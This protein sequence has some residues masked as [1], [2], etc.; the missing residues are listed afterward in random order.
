MGGLRRTLNELS[1]AHFETKE[2]RQDPSH[3]RATY[4][5]FPSS[6]SEWGLGKSIDLINW[7]YDLKTRRAREENICFFGSENEFDSNGLRCG[8]LPAFHSPPLVV[9]D[10]R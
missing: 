1:N 10:A 3:R 7:N 5:Q 2:K 6:P 4:G 8:F 9:I